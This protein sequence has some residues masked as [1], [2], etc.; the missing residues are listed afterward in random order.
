MLTARPSVIVE[1]PKGRFIALLLK[2]LHSA[3]VTLKNNTWTLKSMQNNS[4]ADSFV[5]HCKYVKIGMCENAEA[6]VHPDYLYREFGR[7]GNTIV[8][9]E[10]Q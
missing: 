10:D 5:W 6:N 8:P 1:C 4:L 2:S 9:F 7:S 3:A